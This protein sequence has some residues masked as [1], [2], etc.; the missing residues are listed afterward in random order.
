MVAVLQPF[1]RRYERL[2]RRALEGELNRWGKWIERHSDFEGYP[3][4]NVLVAF[5]MGR[6]GNSRGHKILCLD[7]PTDVYSIHH[8]ILMLTDTLQEAVWLCYVTRLKPDG[9]LW[10]LEERCQKADIESDALKQRL[11]RAKNKLL[12]LGE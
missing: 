8:R 6:G 9:T 12:G 4:A 1:D 2:E 5:L 11:K 3:G 7:M 10:S